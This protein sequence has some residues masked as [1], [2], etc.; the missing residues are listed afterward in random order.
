MRWRDGQIFEG[1]RREPVVV[2]CSSHIMTYYKSKVGN[3]SSQRLTCVRSWKYHTYHSFFHDDAHPPCFHGGERS[4]PAFLRSISS[5]PPRL[6]DTPGC[7]LPNVVGRAGANVPLLHTEWFVICS[8]S[9][10]LLDVVGKLLESTMRICRGHI[11]PAPQ[12]S[13]AAWS[14]TP[15]SAVSKLTQQFHLGGA[16]ACPVIH[17]MD[18]EGFPEG[19]LASHLFAAPV[20][21]HVSCPDS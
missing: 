4:S 19:P 15:S 11:A 3:R 1:L 8:G 9:P 14:R 7:F 6:Q 20:E 18:C 21:D 17:P 16:A 10:P 2:K 13:G 12:D 5:S